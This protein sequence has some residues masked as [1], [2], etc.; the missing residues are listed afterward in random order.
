[1]IWLFGM[2]TGAFFLMFLSDAWGVLWKKRGSR[3][4]FYTGCLMLAASVVPLFWE[5]KPEQIAA[6]LPRMCSAVAA[7]LFFLLLLYT[8]FFAPFSSVT[9]AGTE[10]GKQPLADTGVYA[11]CRHPGVLWFGLAFFFFWCAAGGWKAAVGGLWLTLLDILYVL[12]QDAR[13]FPL[14]ISRYAEYQ[15]E[16]PFLLPDRESIRRCL[17]G[18]RKKRD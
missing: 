4:W 6:D 10:E 12:W 18:L 5:A 8:V 11:L 13:I 3:F 1:M 7:G 9:D 2:G 16:T 15:K 14:S 17:N